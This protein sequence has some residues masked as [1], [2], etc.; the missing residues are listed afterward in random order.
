MVNRLETVMALT[1]G[2]HPGKVVEHNNQRYLRSTHHHQFLVTPE[3]TSQERTSTQTK[4]KFSVSWT[5]N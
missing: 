5:S 3:D 2:A 4:V 1:K